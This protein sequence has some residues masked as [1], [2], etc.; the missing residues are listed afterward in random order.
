MYSCRIEIGGT[1]Q[2]MKEK[3]LLYGLGNFFSQYEK[4]INEK[5]DI[6]A[7]IDKQKTGEYSGKQ[8]IH[9]DGEGHWDYK[10]IIVMLYDIQECLRVSRTLI[11]MGVD[12]KKILLGHSLYGEFSECFE[13]ISVLSDGN[14]LL[15]RGGLHLKV[16]SKDEF[17]NV[18]EVLIASC[19][20]YYLNND[21]KDIVLDV[22]MNIGGASAFFISRKRT[23]KVFG[24]EP[25]EETFA[26]AKDNL[27]EYLSNPEK[28]EIFHYGISGENSE[29]I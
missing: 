14:I 17:N 25:F 21:K 28:I 1:K 12:C 22:G 9:I 6:A 10:Y 15:A 27:K 29:Q 18:Y 16:R 11:S 20:D 8:I 26:A 13:S 24:Y 3:I 7:F 4:E 2:N 5:Y 23:Q 19:Y